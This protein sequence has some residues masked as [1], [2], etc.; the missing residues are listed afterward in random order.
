MVSVYRFSFSDNIEN[1]SRLFSEGLQNTPPNPRYVIDVEDNGDGKIDTND[2]FR[3]SAGTQSYSLQGGEG[4]TL[5]HHYLNPET[6]RRLRLRE[7]LS[8]LESNQGLPAGNETLDSIAALDTNELYRVRRSEAVW[9]INGELDPR[10]LLGQRTYTRAENEAWTRRFSSDNSIRTFLATPGG[11]HMSDYAFYTGDWGR[12]I[13]GDMSWQEMRFGQFPEKIIVGM[14]FGALSFAS[15]AN[16]TWHTFSTNFTSNRLGRVLTNASAENTLI[17]LSR[18]RGNPALNL[19]Q[20][21]QT[22]DVRTEMARG[23][24][25]FGFTDPVIVLACA[26]DMDFWRWAKQ[27]P[28]RNFGSYSILGLWGRNISTSLSGLTE[29][30]QIGFLNSARAAMGLTDGFGAGMATGFRGL[31]SGALVAGS[32]FTSLY[33]AS[34]IWYAFYG[35]L[36]YRSPANKIFSA[37]STILSEAWILARASEELR[38]ITSTTQNPS[39]ALSVANLMR[40]SAELT[41]TSRSF[42]VQF[43]ELFRDFGRNFPIAHLLTRRIIDPSLRELSMNL[44][45]AATN[46]QEANIN[47]ETITAIMGGT[48]ARTRFMSLMNA[49]SPRLLN[50]YLTRELASAGRTVLKAQQALVSAAESAETAGNMGRL[51]RLMQ[52]AATRLAPYNSNWLA[53]R[54]ESFLVRNSVVRLGT[55]LEP[56]QRAAQSARAL[57]SASQAG[58]TRAAVQGA[59]ETVGGELAQ[60]VEAAAHVVRPGGL[61]Q[62]LQAAEAGVEG[63]LGNAAQAAGHA[64]RAG[65]AEVV[66]AV[67]GSGARAIAPELVAA[68]AELTGLAEVGGGAAALVEV[69][70]GVAATTAAAETTAVTVAATVESATLAANAIMTGAAAE[71]GLVVAVG[72]AVGAGVGTGIAYGLGIY[73]ESFTPRDALRDFGRMIFG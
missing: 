49:V 4:A 27:V 65:A 3:L 57:L 64:A 29:T 60:V 38:N 67:V 25:Y 59:V 28:T 68:G 12:F 50:G 66:E 62:A 14:T 8:L 63:V 58:V 30:A 71:V 26:A 15:S 1:S 34:Q 31:A 6:L 21:I 72:L 37:G 48:A 7:N 52:A 51:G 32:A 53:S 36:P 9:T 20:N 47:R 56:V 73:D 54:V 11:I 55:A 22:V 16:A 40:A 43:V 33:E 44:R 42:N 10:L 13:M 18:D 70:S 19:Q 69:G 46:L 35:H 45:K 17:D 2:R 5:L 39:G 61:P 24:L 41:R 23:N